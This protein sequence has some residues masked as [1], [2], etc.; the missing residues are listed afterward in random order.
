ME[1]VR[2]SPASLREAPSPQRGE[3]TT[4][5]SPEAA[6]VSECDTKFMGAN[7]AG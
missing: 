3:G 2:P 4:T 6:H 5:E 1:T 7:W